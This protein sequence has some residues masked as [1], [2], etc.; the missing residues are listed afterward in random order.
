MIGEEALRFLRVAAEKGFLDPEAARAI[1]DEMG[2]NPD[3]KPIAFQ[4]IDRGVLTPEQVDDVLTGMIRSLDEMV[5]EGDDLA[6]Q[7]RFTQ[8][9]T[10]FDRVLASSEAHETAR[11]KKTEALI[12]KRRYEDALWE[13]DELVAADT[14]RKAEA[15]NCRGVV[16]AQIGRFEK[17]AADHEA[18]TRLR[19]EMAKGHFDLGVALHSLKRLEE[20]IAAYDRC[21][22]LDPQYI[23]ALNNKGIALLMGRNLVAAREAWEEALRIES[24]RRTILYNLKAVQK[25]IDGA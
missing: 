1:E 11:W 19:P 6:H 24:K 18:A 14:G 9:F 21:L 8:A 7:H 25:K 20:A 22:A 13:L 17:A 15:L 12:E 16:H 2:R 23:E 4:L 10:R 5:A 3:R